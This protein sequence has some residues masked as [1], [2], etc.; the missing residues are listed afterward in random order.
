MQY[1]IPEAGMISL[2]IFDLKGRE[3]TTLM[4]GPVS[5][6]THNTAWNG[7]N[8]LDEVTVSGLYFVTLRYKNFTLSR[9]I[10]L[11]R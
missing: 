11:L 2:K 9:K 4:E 7:R 1:I 5:N 10:T 3:I 6:G 8:D